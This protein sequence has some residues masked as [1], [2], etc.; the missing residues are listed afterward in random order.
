MLTMMTTTM[1]RPQ[2][3]LLLLPLPQLH[4]QPQQR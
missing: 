4:H 1:R 2:R 3:L